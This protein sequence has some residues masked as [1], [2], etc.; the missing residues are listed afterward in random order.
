VSVP[1]GW[2][3][4]RDPDLRPDRWGA[5]GVLAR[6]QAAGDPMADLIGRQQRLSDLS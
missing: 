4:L 5:H 6:I 3:E 1:I 2:D